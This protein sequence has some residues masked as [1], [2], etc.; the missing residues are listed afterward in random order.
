MS[1]HLHAGKGAGNPGGSRFD[2]R[3]AVVEVCSYSEVEG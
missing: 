3:E 1:L 2:G